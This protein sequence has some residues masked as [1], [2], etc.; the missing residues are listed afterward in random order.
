M[1]RN[2]R[3]QR[4]RLEALVQDTAGYGAL[5]YLA[6]PG[7]VAF[8]TPVAPNLRGYEVVAADPNG[9]YDIWRGGRMVQVGLNRSQA[10]TWLAERMPPESEV[11]QNI[12]RWT[13]DTLRY[14]GIPERQ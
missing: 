3:E 7:D 13:E 6:W 1:I 11:E 2:E 8:L 14:Y 4:K 12:V 10:A 9:M 5:L